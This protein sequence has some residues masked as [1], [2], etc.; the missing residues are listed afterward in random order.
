VAY[1]R[2]H[3][4]RLSLSVDLASALGATPRFIGDGD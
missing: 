2:A 4:L 3:E 1:E